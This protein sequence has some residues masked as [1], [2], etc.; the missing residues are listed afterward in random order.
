MAKTLEQ[1]IKD[2]KEALDRTDKDTPEYTAAIAKVEALTSV[3]DAGITKTQDDLNR[4]DRQAKEGYENSVKETL[5]MTLDE[6]KQVVASV[7][8]SLPGDSGE[9]EG[10]E[11]GNVLERMQETIRQQGEQIKSANDSNTNLSRSLYSERVENNLRRAFG[12]L[13]VGEG[14][15][16]RKVSLKDGRFDLVRRLAGE[17]ELVE[18]AM[19]GETLDASVFSERVRTV[20]AGM[21]EVFDAEGENLGNGS[22][23]VA[24]HRVKEEASPG[25]PATP[26]SRET[27]EITDE[28]RAARASSVY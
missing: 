10:E 9:G 28:D 5:G 18:K 6:F 24:G 20:Y 7:E 15:D 8:E 13:E 12:E 14:D 25:I 3:R 17:D 22:A 2:A 19:N 26:S 21:P 16:K 11:E 1:L 27:S 4:I 23:T